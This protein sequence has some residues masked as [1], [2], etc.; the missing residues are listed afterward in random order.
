MTTK[1]KTLSERA[2]LVSLNV[3]QWSARKYDKRETELV[4]ARNGIDMGVARVNKSLLPMDGPL[5]AVHKKTSEIRAVYAKHT[6]PWTQEGIQIL[7]ADQYIAFTQLMRP[8]MDEWEKLVRDFVEAY[9]IMR[10]QAERMLCGLFRADDY[11][12]NVIDK[13]RI[14]LNFAPVPDVQDWRVDVGDEER[15]RLAK[16]IQARLAE[17][18]STVMTEAWKRIY[19]VISR[20]HERLANP[21]NIFRD[22]LIENAVELCSLLPGLNITDDPELERMRREIEGSLCAYNPDTLRKD[23]AVRQDTADKM[24]ELMAKMGAF[25]TPAA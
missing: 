6:M 25:Y 12:S 18:Q 20:A 22:S 9:P 19:D 8:L 24:A 5:D 3:S 17:A 4:A 15:E 2:M 11:P 10:H 13:F 7:K 14:G 21:D 1:I 23:P 16:H